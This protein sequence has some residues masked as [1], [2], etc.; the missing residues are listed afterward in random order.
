MKEDIAKIREVAQ[1]LLS[2]PQ[3]LDTI[4]QD[5]LK[6]IMEDCCSIIGGEYD[7]SL[8]CDFADI[9]YRIAFRED[10]SLEKC[11]QIYW[12][13]KFAFF[14]TSGLRFRTGSLDEL[15]RYIFDF[16]KSNT[17]HDSRSFIPKEERNTDTI[18]VITSQFLELGHAPTRRVM[19][20]SYALQHDLKKHVIIINDAGMNYYTDPELEMGGRLNFLEEYNNSS[21]MK[22]K[23]ELFRF[24]QVSVLTPNIDVL[25]Q[26]ADTIYS[27][28]PALVYNI[29]GSCLSADLCDDFTTVV[30]LPCAYT[31][32]V[33]CCS[34]L[35]LGRSLEGDARA[36]VD[37]A[38]GKVDRELLP[39]GRGV[40]QPYQNVVETTYNFAYTEPE[41]IK[42]T[43]EEFGLQEDDFVACIV[44]NRLEFEMDADFIQAISEAVYE[45]C[46][47]EDNS[48]GSRALKIVFIGP[49]SS[50]HEIEDKIP[51]KYREK[52]KERFVYT[53]PVKGA[54]EL[55]KLFDITL[56][57]KR[58]GGGRAAFEGL[59]FGKPSV[60][61]RKGDVYWA[62]VREFGVDSW[63]E[64]TQRILRL[65]NDTSFYQEMSQ[66]AFDRAEQIS[67]ITGTQKKL[68]MDLGIM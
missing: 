48:A 28:K 53:G 5:D 44:G 54:S 64:F 32:P 19:D 7:V 55:I 37:G 52:C 33:S 56:N 14:V 41:D 60:T 45:D 51:E 30:S 31:L 6:Q 2:N 24:F 34:N 46:M 42:Y 12:N 18:V 58:E 57:P 62:G 3:V 17:N 10:M 1:K 26:L 65:K 8:K 9:L 47:S 15:Y 59:N 22:Y 61:P 16:I 27:I 20:Y 39:P 11:W 67:D 50:P 4:S 36:Q 21:Y 66:K 68:L 63:T 35:L 29:G 49:L 38:K 25:E 43:R 23:G 13:L 40:I